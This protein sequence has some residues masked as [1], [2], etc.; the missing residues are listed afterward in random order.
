MHDSS[1]DLGQAKAGTTQQEKT[2]N[3]KATLKKREVACE[4][5]K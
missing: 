4:L 1:C 3:D 2:K 5:L